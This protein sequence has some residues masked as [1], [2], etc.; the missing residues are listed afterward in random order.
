MPQQPVANAENNFTQG[1]KTEYTGMNFPENAATSTDNCVFTLIGNV[2]RREGIDFELNQSSA[3]ITT[4]GKAISS[5]VWTNAGGDGVSKIVVVQIGGTLHFY[6]SSTETID[7]PLSAQ[8]LSS[9]IDL[10]AFTPV[11]GTSPDAE[12]CQYTA[13]N[14]FLFVFHPLTEPFYC[15]NTAGTITATQITVK[16]R[17]FTGIEEPGVDDNFRPPTLSAIHQYNLQNQ[18]WS[19]A[20]AWTATSTTTNNSFLGSKT[21]TV[22]AGLTITPGQIVSIVGTAP[23]SP[24]AVE[25]GTV[26]SYSGTTLTIN[27]TSS[28]FPGP[29]GLSLSNWTFNSTSTSK[30]TTWNSVAGNFP[31]NSDV[32]W[33]FKNTSNAFDP[34][35]TIVNVTLGAGPAPKGFYILEAWQQFRSTVSGV[36]GLADVTT[37]F[38]PKTGAWYQGRVWYSGVDASG[39]TE[40]IYFSQIVEKPEQFGRCYQTNDPTSEDR[41]DLLPTDGGLIRIQGCGSIYKLFP[42]QN[43][44]LVFA[45]NGIW[46]ITGSQGIGF[47]AN[48]FTVVPVSDVRSIS[49]TSIVSAQG[50]PI[51]WNEEGIWFV[52]PAQQGGQSQG[53]GQYERLS[54]LIVNNLA[55]GTILSFYNQIPL[56]SKKYVRGDYDPINYII[57]WTYRSTEA[58]NVTQRYQYDRV[59]NFNTSNRAFYPWTIADSGVAGSPKVNGVRFVTA[60][61]GLN[62]PQ[63]IL[64]Y[65]TSYTS[66]SVARVT[67][68]E[69][70]DSTNWK[71]W[72]STSPVDYTSFFVTGYRLHGQAQKKFQANYIYMYINNYVNMSYRLQG[73]WDYAISGSSGKFSSLEQIFTS[74]LPA[75]FSVVHRRHRIRGRGLVLQF[76]V[77]STTGSPFDIIGWSVDER[78]NTSV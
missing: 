9:T 68:S 53:G 22:Q 15:I 19:N 10:S 70:R 21:W 52:A 69:E 23:S 57:Q 49:G 59:L 48:D 61:G 45:A 11:G 67:F 17:D 58:I 51:F 1:L 66:A 71:D 62:S 31:S 3:A 64:K 2:K 25:S 40:N 8:K 7:S 37:T 34:A 6:R 14:G 38:R 56:S 43:G 18:G 75:H 35:T 12:E 42:L 29:V 4:A 20:A 13:G 39:F 30:I 73:L 24:S 74:E 54:G 78:L 60:P 32:W 26:T 50:Y 46:F 77:T 5:F 44:M 47:A 72:Q 36:A 16:I 41:F 63:S 33:Y 76:K 28:N 55:L 65:I 27:V